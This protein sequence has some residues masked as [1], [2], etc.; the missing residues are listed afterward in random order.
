MSDLTIK[1]ERFAQRYVEHGNASEAYR[2]SYD[3]SESAP[4]T[5]SNEGYKLTQNPEVAARI[6]ELQELRLRRHKVTADRVI[7]EMAKLAFGDIRKAY[8]ADGNLK[9]ITE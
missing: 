7:A 1:Q 4:E 2:Q 9:A 3:C 8:N 5:I 6:A